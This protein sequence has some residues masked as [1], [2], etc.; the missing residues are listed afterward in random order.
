MLG[1]LVVAT[2]MACRNN[3]GSACSLQLQRQ[4][5]DARPLRAILVSID[6]RTGDTGAAKRP[7]RTPPGA[8]SSAWPALNSSRSDTSSTYSPPL[9]PPFHDNVPSDGRSGTSAHRL[10]ALF[11]NRRQAANPHDARLIPHVP[12]RVAGSSPQYRRIMY[13]TPGRRTSRHAASMIRA[14]SAL[15]PHR[16][17]N[18]VPGAEPQAAPTS[19]SVKGA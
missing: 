19:A 13:S 12:L 3:L 6:E 5:P 15:R 1:A 9:N 8:V 10:N 18:A 16:T 2:R 7:Q 11:W 4:P 14:S 17:S